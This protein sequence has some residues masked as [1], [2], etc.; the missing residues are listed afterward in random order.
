MSSVQIFRKGSWKLRTL[1]VNGDPWFVAKDVA[2]ALGYSNPQK[3]V[4]DHCKRPKPAG[5]NVSFT[6][7][8]P[9]T[10]I[11]SEPDLYRLV[12]KSEMPEAVAFEAWIFEELIPNVR[13]NGTF[14]APGALAGMT[15]LPRTLSGALIAEFRKM[16]GDEGARR[17][18]D[19]LIGFPSTPPSV[20][21][22]ASTR[23]QVAGPAGPDAS[24]DSVRHQI[25]ELVSK[26]AKSFGGA[27]FQATWIRLYRE[28]G[29]RHGINVY[30]AARPMKLEPLDFLEKEGKLPELYAVAILIF[31]KG[32]A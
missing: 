28:F 32:V 8:D 14:V 20:P 29:S 18:V 11:I 19:Y 10:T 31:G 12:V 6:P 1:E 22:P 3:A 25:S 4:R 16:F 5:V 15:R 9:Q 21:A 30:E 24:D 26:Y 7:L 23:P 13:R 17:R 27:D 2:E